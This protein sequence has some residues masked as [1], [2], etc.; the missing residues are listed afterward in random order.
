MSYE[1]AQAQFQ[2]IDVLSHVDPLESK[3]VE[4]FS[5]CHCITTFNDPGIP[6][7]VQYNQ[8]KWLNLAEEVEQQTTAGRKQMLFMF[9]FW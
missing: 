4:T 3:P 1:N 2:K 7:K 9:V 6:K 8:S 5:I